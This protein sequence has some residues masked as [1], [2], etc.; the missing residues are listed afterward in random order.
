MRSRGRGPRSSPRRAGP[1][2]AAAGRHPHTQ[3]RAHVRGHRPA[4]TTSPTRQTSIAA[5][6]RPAGRHAG[7]AGL[8]HHGGRRRRRDALPAP[9]PTMPTATSTPSRRCSSIKDVVPGLSDGGAHVGTIC[10][11][12]FPTTLLEHWARDRARGR[13]AAFE[14]VIQRQARD[15]ARAVGLRDR[16]VLAPGYRADIN[17]IDMTALRLHRAADASTTCRPAAG[18]WCSAPTATGTRSSRARKHTGNGVATGSLPG[19]LIRGP[20]A[21]PAL[22]E[23]AVRSA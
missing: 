8:G 11:G 2:T 21:A 14:F 13:T 9:L 23:N 18:G 20:Q 10:D 5:R 6:R 1:R 4:A 12:S 22:T 7:G 19:R 16:G 17:V 15:T 3:V